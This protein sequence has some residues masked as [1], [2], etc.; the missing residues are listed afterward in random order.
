[1]RSGAGADR[2][3][4][5]RAVPADRL[6]RAAPGRTAAAREEL[7][8]ASRRRRAAIRL[9]CDPT[10]VVD[11]H[12]QTVFEA[13]P[14]I[15]AE[16]FR[17]GTQAIA[18]DG[19]WLA[20]VHEVSERDKRRYYQHRFV[21]FDS[22][23]QLRRVSRPFYFIKKGVEF[24][25]GLA[26]A[27]DGKVLLISFGVEDG[28]A[29]IATVEADEV[30][31]LLED[32]EQLPSGASESSV[33]AAA[34]AEKIRFPGMRSTP[35]VDAPAKPS[36]SWTPQAPSAGTEL[37]VA[38][39]RERMGAELDRINLKVNHPGD[40]KTDDRPRVVWMHHDV[41]QHWVQWCKDKALVDSVDCF[42]FVSNWQRQRYLDAFGLPPQRCVV[43]RHALDINPE[44]RRWE[45]GTDLALRL[46]EHA[47][48]RTFRFA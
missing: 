2:R 42:V 35:I 40:D 11:E 31:R 45:A 19:G 32:I 22:A 29:W 21:W 37:M 25:A 23:G 18:F 46:Y 41:N 3:V 15:A 20:L 13:T 17:G 9:S 48:S 5:P 33:R 43:L 12:A 39:L 1:M 47:V 4:S 8:A 34:S 6:A 16:Q 10:R 44:V 28:E 24:A 7:D 36:S 26:R 27:P 14:A 38:G 30:R